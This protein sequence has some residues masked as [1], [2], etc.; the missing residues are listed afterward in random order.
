[1][2]LLDR[3]EPPISVL[4][5]D[6]VNEVSQGPAEGQA[7]QGLDEASP[8]KA[9]QE[10]DEGIES[11]RDATIP[12]HQE[13]DVGAPRFVGG[14]ETAGSLLALIGNKSNVTTGPAES[15]DPLPGCH[16]HAAFPVVDE[17]PVGI[18][19]V[20]LDHRFHSIT[21]LRSR[22]EPVIP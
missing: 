15:F 6:A 22:Q 1:L 21:T 8:A 9:G 2:R 19:A 14:T 4:G 20:R 17:D 11:R 5:H 10:R 16:T 18:G 12:I 3:P 7:E 13:R